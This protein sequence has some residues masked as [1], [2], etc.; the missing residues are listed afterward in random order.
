MAPKCLPLELLFE[1]VPFIPAEKAAPN[2]LS[3]CL[4]LH[5]LLLPRV[6]KWK[7]LKKMI[8]ELRD[9][10]FGKIDELRDEMNQKFGQINTRLDRTDQRLDQMDKRLD[11]MDQRLDQFEQYGPVPPPMPLQSGH[12]SGIESTSEFSELRQIG[13]SAAFDT[14]Q[15]TGSEL[16]RRPPFLHHV[17]ETGNPVPILSSIGLNALFTPLSHFYFGNCVPSMT[18]PI[19]PKDKPNVEFDVDLGH[20]L[21]TQNVGDL[22]KGQR[23]VLADPPMQLFPRHLFESG[24]ASE[25]ASDRKE[26]M[27]KG[28]KKPSK[29]VADA[30]LTPSDELNKTASIVPTSV[31]T[32]RRHLSETGNRMRNLFRTNTLSYSF[33]K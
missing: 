33:K 21:S 27:G 10:V 14:R 17:S 1:I 8:K 4:L 25:T 32:F 19:C 31:Q 24:E 11:R 9:E 20:D 30:G 29:E 23:S 13:T 6:I 26:S 7:E 22:L 15:N 28:R 5:N 3:S 12:Y 18:S 2:A 16:Q